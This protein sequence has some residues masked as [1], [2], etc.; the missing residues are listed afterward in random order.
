MKTCSARRRW[1]WR[2]SRRRASSPY[3]SRAGSSPT[4]VSSRGPWRRAA[5][6]GRAEGAGV[7]GGGGVGGGVAVRIATGARRGHCAGK[8][9]VPDEPLNLRAQQRLIV[10]VQP[11]D[12]MGGETAAQPSIGANGADLVRF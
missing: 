6:P 2:G 3:T 11:V 5:G 10:R 1:G 8:V 4:P 12:Q 7:V 9:I